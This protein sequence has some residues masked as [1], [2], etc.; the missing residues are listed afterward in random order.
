RYMRPTYSPTKPM[1]SNCTPAKTSKA[2][3]N[4]PHPAGVSY[5]SASKMT[6]SVARKPMPL[7]SRPRTELTAGSASKR[8]YFPLAPTSHLPGAST[9]PLPF[10]NDGGLAQVD[11]RPARRLAQQ[12]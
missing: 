3:M 2:H 12:P 8:G 6:G 11:H 4:D 9:S 10:R 7:N 1:V 5:T